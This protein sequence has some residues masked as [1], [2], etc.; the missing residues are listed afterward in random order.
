MSLSA[1]ESISVKIRNDN[2][3][4]KNDLS[5]DSCHEDIFVVSDDDDDDNNN[6]IQAALSDLDPQTVK[7]T[8]WIAPSDVV[9]ANSK[10]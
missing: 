9:L 8:D 1:N 4:I 5:N 10:R 2:D 3:E 6:I 7:V